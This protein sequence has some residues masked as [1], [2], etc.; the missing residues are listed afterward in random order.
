MKDR[1]VGRF[2]LT[3]GSFGFVVSACLVT[4]LTQGQI[5]DT[6]T[7]E[8]KRAVD[9]NGDLS[10]VHFRA[11]YETRF[12][13]LD[14]DADGFVSKAE[15]LFLS[16][17]PRSRT[18]ASSDV[19]AKAEEH[20][21]AEGLPPQIRTQLEIAETEFGIFDENKDDQLSRAEMM[22]LVDRMTLL[23]ENK[24]DKLDRR[25]M[26]AIFKLKPDQSE[27]QQRKK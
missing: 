11:K 8:H 14:T 27:S 12:N 5:P 10:L 4:T 16:R 23:D 21:N 15:Y 9:S 17:Y 20:A 1:S 3:L 26:V 24:D 19:D 7:T 25:E 18:L 22:A 2:R 13:R 6:D